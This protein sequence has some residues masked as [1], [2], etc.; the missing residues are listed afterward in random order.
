[1][2]NFT[3]ES[4]KRSKFHFEKV[5]DIMRTYEVHEI[6]N[7]I[8]L[9]VPVV[10]LTLKHVVFFTLFCSHINFSYVGKSSLTKF[11]RGEN[12]NNV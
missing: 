5:H 4:I 12:G 7:I 3:I 1:M 9:R 6:M 10:H 8:G 11:G 2:E